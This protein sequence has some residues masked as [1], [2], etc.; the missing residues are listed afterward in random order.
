[1]K[2]SAKCN[3]LNL[4]APSEKYKMSLRVLNELHSIMATLIRVEEQVNDLWSRTIDEVR[5][6]NGKKPN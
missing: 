4:Y 5:I 2:E 6:Q 3:K 1:M